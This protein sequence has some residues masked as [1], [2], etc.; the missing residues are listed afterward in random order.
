MFQC[1]PQTPFCIPVPTPR[2]S[3]AM[4]VSA[5]QYTLTPHLKHL[6][7]SQGK[8]LSVGIELQT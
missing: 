8:L 3:P 6:S 2:A 4:L 1:P 5:T 7:T